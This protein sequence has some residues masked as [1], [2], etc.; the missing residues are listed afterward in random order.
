MRSP[1]T[2][3]LNALAALSCSQDPSQQRWTCPAGWVP[4]DRGGRG[5]AALLCAPSGGAAPGACEGHPS[6][7]P[8]FTASD[9]VV[10]RGFACATDGTIV[11]GFPSL[12]DEEIPPSDFEP[13][14]PTGAPSPSFAPSAPRM[15]CPRG[16]VARDELC[17]P[18][19]SM[20]CGPYAGPLPDD[21]CTATADC[22]SSPFA[23]APVGA[24]LRYVRA[25]APPGG[26][27]TIEPPVRRARRSA[28]TR[29]A[30]R[31]HPRR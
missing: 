28:A 21:S 17:A 7:P 3:A 5:P 11:G 31:R 23:D 18:T 8:V 13:S 4:S 12:S 10:H 19:L 9:A 1:A 2:F 22:P 29:P 24:A 20:S 16:W 27:G 30:R 14:P 26:D 15:D 6:T 25:D